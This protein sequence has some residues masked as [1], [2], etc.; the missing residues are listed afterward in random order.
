MTPVIY[1]LPKVHK[2]L[3]KP[4]GRPI[5][6]NINSL[7]CRLGEYLDQYLQPPVSKGKSYLNDSKQL[8]SEIKDIQI[9]EDDFL[10][11]IDGNSL[12]KNIEQKD[13]LNAK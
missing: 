13:G 6:S 2:N 1:Y 12:Y 11:T 9:G 5:I 8:S 7:F 4:P 3:S 10:V